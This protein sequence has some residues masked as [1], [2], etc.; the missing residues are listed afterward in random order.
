MLVDK[1]FLNTARLLDPQNS[2]RSERPG[3]EDHQGQLHPDLRQ[4]GAWGSCWVRACSD[5]RSHSF[6]LVLAIRCGR[7]DSGYIDLLILHGLCRHS[8]FRGSLIAEG[9]VSHIAAALVLSFQAA[10]IR[11]PCR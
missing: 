8:A 1:S 5:G 9:G 2:L 10:D 3:L 7:L 6:S 11:Q 4:R